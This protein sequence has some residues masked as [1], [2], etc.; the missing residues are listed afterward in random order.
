MREDLVQSQAS[1]RLLQK[2]WRCVNHDTGGFR[3]FVIAV[4]NLLDLRLNKVELI[5]LLEVAGDAGRAEDGGGIS[6]GA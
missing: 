3:H 5:R 4:G 2:A 6:L 1:L